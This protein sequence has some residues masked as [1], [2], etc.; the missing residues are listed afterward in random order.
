MEPPEELQEYSDK[1]VDYFRS[2]DEAAA[3][4]VQAVK[5][6]DLSS[7]IQFRQ[8]F[9]TALAESQALWEEAMSYLGG[10]SKSVDLYIEQGKGLAERIQRL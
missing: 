3:T 4:V 2:I 7:F 1:L 5:P 10:M 6:E 9:G 8:W